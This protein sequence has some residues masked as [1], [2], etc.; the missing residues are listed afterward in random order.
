MPDEDAEPTPTRIDVSALPDAPNPSD[1]K[2]EIDEVVD[3]EE[4]GFNVIVAKPG[5]KLPWGYHHHPNHEEFLYVIEGTV[6]FETADGEREVGEN[7][8][9]FVPPGARQKGV[10][11]GDEPARVVAVGAPKASDEAVLEEPCPDCGERTDR[12]YEVI[13]EDGETV[14]A[15]SCA[16]CGAETDRLH[17]GPS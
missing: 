2:K 12:E 11:V 4:L 15:L 9:L 17:A 10:A 14:I 1:H 6:R 3:S 8:A 5:Q 16:A 13:E 7:E